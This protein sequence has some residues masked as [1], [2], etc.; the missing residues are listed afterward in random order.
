MYYHLVAEIAEQHRRDLLREAQRGRLGREATSAQ[1][2]PTRRL[3]RP[4]LVDFP[5]HRR[6]APTA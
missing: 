3:R 4:Y 1:P 2:K 5:S 6:P